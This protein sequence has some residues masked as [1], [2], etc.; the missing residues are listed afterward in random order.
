MKKDI[1][2][3]EVL[4][5]IAEDIAFYL[6]SLDVKEIEFVDKELQTVE[7]RES[8]LIGHCLIN[9]IESILHLEIQNDNDST[10]HLRMLR[11]YALIKTRYPDLPIHQCVIYIGRAKM[12]M[13]DHIQSYGLSYHYQLIDMHNIDCETLIAIDKPSALVLA[14][15]C[16]FKG[17]P[18]TKS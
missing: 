13:I 3:K 14:V 6:L 12:K 11:Y 18:E 10:M 16:D 17:K 7:K 1:T 2:T 8:D 5:Q 4:K 9:G 15:L